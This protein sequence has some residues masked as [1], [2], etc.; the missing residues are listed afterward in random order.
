MP[1]SLI[2][3]SHFNPRP[4]GLFCNFTSKEKKKKTEFR[5]RSNFSISKFSIFYFRFS[6]FFFLFFPRNSVALIPDIFMLFFFFL[7]C[8]R[9]PRAGDTINK[10]ARK[11]QKLLKLEFSLNKA[12]DLKITKQKFK[13]KKN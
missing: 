5:K 3:F 7:K 4:E 9:W 6:F 12:E 1:T 11:F 13:K 2:D 8:L 10:N